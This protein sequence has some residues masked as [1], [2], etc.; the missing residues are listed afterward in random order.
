MYVEIAT[1]KLQNART[2]IH[3]SM[4][5]TNAQ[6]SQIPL[7]YT[8]GSMV[9]PITEGTHIK[10]NSQ[11]V[12]KPKMYVDMDLSSGVYSVTGVQQRVSMD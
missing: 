10:R 12:F 1:G 7:K 11:D 5:N 8:D 6:V 2:T 4:V 3:G 9:G